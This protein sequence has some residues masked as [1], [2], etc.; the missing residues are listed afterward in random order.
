[1]KR[2]AILPRGLGLGHNASQKQASAAPSKTD[3][4]PRVHQVEHTNKKKD[5][6]HLDVIARDRGLKRLAASLYQR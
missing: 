4:V 3:R 1:M 5:A 2:I 6:I